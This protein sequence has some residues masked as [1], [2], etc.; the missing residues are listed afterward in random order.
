MAFK[1]TL[2]PTLIFSGEPAGS[3][4]P[5]VETAGA[6]NSSE[7]RL[8]LEAREIVK[9]AL[10]PENHQRCNCRAEIDA[11]DWDNRMPMR[12]ALTALRCANKQGTN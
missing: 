5:T 7:L 6:G 4:P 9:A 8:L 3:R 12:V 11:G 10:S 2:R 1:Q